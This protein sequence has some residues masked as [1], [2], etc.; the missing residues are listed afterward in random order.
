MST[1]PTRSKPTRPSDI[2]ERVERL[3]A[4]TEQD[5][6]P[7]RTALQDLYASHQQQLHRI[8]RITR[9]SDQYQTTAHKEKTNLTERFEKS[10][11]QLERITRISDRY[12]KM[13]QDLNTELKRASTHDHLTALANRRLMVD[14]LAEEVGR[15]Q[16]TGRPFSVA[17]CDIDYFKAIN[18]THGHAA[19]DAVL[20]AF[21]R[22]VG[23][24]LREY[25]LMARWGGE[26]FLIVLPETALAEA[27]AISERLRASIL[28]MA[29][30]VSGTQVT[31]TASFGLAEFRADEDVRETLKRADDALYRAKDT[32]RNRVISD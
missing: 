5:E 30:D 31:V 4:A 15:A 32:G 10:L 14:R 1:P 7:L 11:R 27:L 29:V 6:S 20:V 12:Q 25:D 18:D 21:S 17:I 24:Q 28:S 22:T 3:L 23:T 13:L 9:I 8:E 19:G 2:T 26:E 16:R